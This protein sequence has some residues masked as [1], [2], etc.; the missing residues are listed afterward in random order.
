MVE[1][2]KLELTDRYPF[3]DFS[4]L[5]LKAGLLEAPQAKPARSML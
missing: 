4:I 1:P 2:T 3:L 5:E